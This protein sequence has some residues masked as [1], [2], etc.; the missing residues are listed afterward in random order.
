[1]EH[2][3]QPPNPTN[4]PQPRLLL[5]ACSRRKLPGA[6]PIPAIERY[7]GPA[8]R[9]VRRYLAANKPNRYPQTDIRILSARFGLIPA[10]QPIPE[11][12]ERMT[13]RRAAELK[14]DIDAELSRTLGALRYSHVLLCM[15][16]AY[17]NALGEATLTL[18]NVA[19]LTA[20]TGS[21]G[22]QLVG[23]HGWLYGSTTENGGSVQR[24]M[25]T[26]PERGERGITPQA[27]NTS[28]RGIELTL[29]PDEVLE[30]AREALNSGMG[31][32]EAY[33]TWYVEVDGRRVAP[34]WLVSCLTQLPV[35]SFHSAEARRVLQR[36][37]VTVVCEPGYAPVPLKEGK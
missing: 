37:G 31:K 9:L 10:T 36:L 18:P 11:Y 21:M 27:A 30:A 22:R 19:T 26:G 15:G 17:L 3:L 7:D 13:A 5:L 35:G 8:F 1:M 4:P 12:D 29:T 33:Q 23:L 20:A 16:R 34:K 24:H 6:E 2:P 28:I 25:G 14:P 32:P